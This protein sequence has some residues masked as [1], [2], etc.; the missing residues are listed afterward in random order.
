MASTQAARPSQQAP[1]RPR[2]SQSRPTTSKRPAPIDSG[3]DQKNNPSKMR[4]LTEPYVRD[5]QYILRKHRAKSPS[6]VVH[7][8]PN[9]WRFDNQDGSFAYESPMKTFL[10]HLRAQTVP[11]EMLEELFANNVPFYDGCLIVEVHNH[12][13]SGGKKEGTSRKGED[14][15]KFSMH[16][17]NQHL[18]PSPFAPYP[19]T[20]D[21]PEAESSQDAETAA[22]DRSKS[23]DKDGPKITTIVL[24][25]T[26]QARHEELLIMAKTPA[27]EW[28]KRKGDTGTPSTAQ[29]PTP[30]LPTTP[31]GSRANVKSEKMALEQD[32]LYTFQ[33]D[34]LL[35][36]EPPLFLD[37]V[38]NF[39]ASQA[40]IDMLANP[41][42]NGK[43]PAPKERKR[44]T[45]EMEADDA[46]AAEAERRMLI[47]DE[48]VKPFARTAAGAASSETQAAAASL[49]SSRFKTI[50][51]VRQK[52]EE[53]ERVKKEDETRL[54]QEKRQYEEQAQ[55]QQKMMAMKKQQELQQQQ[56]RQQRAQQQAEMMRQQQ[57]ANQ[58]QQQQQQQANLMQHGHPNQANMVQNQQAN[59]LSAASQ[60][61]PVPRQQTQT[62]MMQSSPMM[63]QPGG[64]PMAPQASNAGSPPRAAPG[65]HPQVDMARTQSQQ[66]NGSRNNTPQMANTPSMAQAMPG[67]RQISQTPRMQPGSPAVSMP[68][69]TPMMPMA[70][71]PQ[72][73]T[74]EQ[75]MMLQQQ[76]AAL[77]QQNHGQQHAGTPNQGQPSAM[78]PEPFQI[79]QHITRLTTMQAQIQARWQQAQQNQDHNAAQHQRVQMAKV[80]QQLNQMKARMAQAQG[81]AMGNGGN[82]NGMSM[83]QQMAAAQMANGG[84]HGH[85]GQQQ[86]Q[87]PQMAQ[88]A[89][90]MHQMAQMQQAQGHTNHQI[91]PNN[92]QQQQAFLAMRAQHQQQL[93]Q[94]YRAHNGNIPQHVIQGMHP[95]MQMLLRQ[96]QQKQAHARQVASN[97]ARMQQQQGGNE[98][99]MQNL[100][101][102]RNQM[103]MQMGG[104]GTPGGGMNNMQ[105]QQQF[106]QQQPQGANLDAS[107]AAMANALQQTNRQQGGGQGM[108]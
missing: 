53:N 12:R 108:Q 99:Y 107:F 40:V 98:Q 47:M 42:H 61:S 94:I 91:D 6:L 57:L 100:Q 9:Y 4:R 45:A 67:S 82:Q 68:A 19:K 30:Q 18:T 63:P 102:V 52:H 14:A 17:Y 5:S 78:G 71:N 72:G 77:A 106:A 93:Q 69:N 21:S 3:A 55:Q 64:F 35:A 86:G 85:P 8:H 95:Q 66:A 26:E 13:G 2:D 44:T 20:E 54:A 24:H 70:Q 80:T 10:Q 46:Q 33:A 23:R 92:Q 28:K 97:Q 84:G 39:E 90:L 75:V 89:Q 59:M 31:G 27:S 29:P 81:M 65:M 103:A 58:Q 50:E 1:R 7:L 22:Q 51:M 87:T 76:R 101:N 41:L 74:P 15:N 96:Q 73:F 49:G 104:M 43:P 56:Q 83:Q 25:Q 37:P 34:A 105:Q 32:D 36:T 88:Q 60:G 38:D 79:A 48:R 16:N 62:P 11:H